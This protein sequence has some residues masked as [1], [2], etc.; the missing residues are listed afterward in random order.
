MNLRLRSM[1]SIATATLFAMGMFG[2]DEPASTAMGADANPETAMQTQSRNNMKQMALA[3][4]NYVSAKK[5]FPTAAIRDKKNGKPLLSWRV[6][7]LPYL[8]DQ[9]IYGEFHLDEPWDSEHNQKLL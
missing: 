1:M 4:H 8:E 3:I 7:I 2:P 5:R 9:T 6:A